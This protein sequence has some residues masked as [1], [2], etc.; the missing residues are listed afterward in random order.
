MTELDRLFAQTDTTVDWDL[1][2]QVIRLAGT[3]FQG[4]VARR[5]RSHGSLP[6]RVLSDFFIGAHAEVHGYRL[7]TM[8]KRLYRAAFPKLHLIKI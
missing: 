1:G 7:M 6:K 2:E 4:Y 8:D 3:A 5:R